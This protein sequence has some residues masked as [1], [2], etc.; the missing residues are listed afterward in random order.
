MGLIALPKRYNERNGEQLVESDIDWLFRIYHLGVPILFSFPP[1]AYEDAVRGF[2]NEHYKVVR[3]KGK[4]RWLPVR[5]QADSELPVA[6][7]DVVW[8]VFRRVH[9]A[10]ERDVQ[11]YREYASLMRLRESFFQTEDSDEAL[12][13]KVEPDE[14]S[15]GCGCIGFRKG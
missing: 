10:I 8:S 9:K 5:F 3:G 7:Y 4:G 12:E 13:G 1:K 6:S 2:L 15:G 11:D 14:S